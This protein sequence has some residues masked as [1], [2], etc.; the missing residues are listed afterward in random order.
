MKL[1]KWVL[2]LGGVIL[3]GTGIF[4]FFYEKQ[5]PQNQLIGMIGVGVL[6]LLAG[7]AIKTRRT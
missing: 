6:L 1:L 2:L 5:T 4:H 3:I 7:S